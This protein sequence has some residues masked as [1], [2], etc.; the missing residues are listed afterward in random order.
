MILHANDKYAR[1]WEAYGH[2]HMVV[3]VHGVTFIQDI[4]LMQRAKIERSKLHQIVVRAK[5]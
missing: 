3:R 1:A 5:N 4:A 2:G